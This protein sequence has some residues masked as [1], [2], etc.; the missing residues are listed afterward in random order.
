M[1]L[2]FLSRKAIHQ[3]G[4][5]LHLCLAS[6]K[7]SLGSVRLAISTLHHRALENHWTF[8]TSITTFLHSTIRSY[9]YLHI[10]ITSFSTNT[11]LWR[12]RMEEWKPVRFRN[13]LRSL[14]ET[15]PAG[16]VPRLLPF[17]L[18]VI[19]LALFSSLS[20][21][22][23]A[24]LNPVMTRKRIRRIQKNIRYHLDRDV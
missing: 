6:L 15:L 22:R 16:M 12:R 18:I 24:R 21:S 4:L 13:A 23:K 17:I 9:L 8:Q 10:L 7:S 5:R 11:V 3:I 14:K 1:K 20:F 19:L 2:V